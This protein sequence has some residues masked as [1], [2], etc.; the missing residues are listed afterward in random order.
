MS[1]TTQSIR[2]TEKEIQRAVKVVERRLASDRGYGQSQ[3]TQFS[4]VICSDGK[5][6]FTQWYLNFINLSGV[7]YSDNISKYGII[8]S[9]FQIEGQYQKDTHKYIRYDRRRIVAQLR[10]SCDEMMKETQ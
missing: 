7:L 5:I 3:V 4:A 2:P 1:E 8:D 6:R 9:T 10:D